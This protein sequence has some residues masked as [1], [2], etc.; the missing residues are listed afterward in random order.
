MT[1]YQKVVL[2]MGG[3]TNLQFCAA[4]VLFIRSLYVNPKLQAHAEE[5]VQD[6]DN[7]THW[8]DGRNVTAL[9]VGIWIAWFTVNSG[10]II[11]FEKLFDWGPL[12]F[13]AGAAGFAAALIGVKWKPPGPTRP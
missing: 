10:I 9:A 13:V 6:G 4:T 7:V 2:L 12:S 8:A 3:F 1:D 11:L 5:S